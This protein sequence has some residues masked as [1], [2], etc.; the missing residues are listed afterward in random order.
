MFV[1]IMYACVYAC[2]YVLLLL[3]AT[4]HFCWANIQSVGLLGWGI[5]PSQDLYLQSEQHKQNKRTQ[6]AMP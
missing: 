6:K 3:M 4:D 1:C 5:S 2:M